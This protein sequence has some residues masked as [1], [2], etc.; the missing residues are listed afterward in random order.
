V[1]PVTPISSDRI[2]DQFT[3]EFGGAA[4]ARLSPLTIRQRLP[5]ILR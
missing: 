2:E 1:N 3:G 4:R 5:F